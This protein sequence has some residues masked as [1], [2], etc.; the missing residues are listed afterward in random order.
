M[1]SNSEAQLDLQPE[2][3]LNDFQSAWNEKDKHYEEKNGVIEVSGRQYQFKVSF[4]NLRGD[5]MGT[6]F[7]TQKRAITEVA[8]QLG[9]NARHDV[10][11]PILPGWGETSAQFEGDFLNLVLEVLQEAGFENPKVLGIN[12]SGRGTPDYIQD[13]SRGRIS[14]IGMMDEVKD[15]SNIANVLMMRGYFGDK[16]YVPNVA[17][18]GHSMGSLDA[19]SFLDSLNY[20]EGPG[21]RNRDEDLRV[22]KFL[23]MMPA[24]DGPFAMVRARFLWAVRKQVMESLKQAIPGKGALSLNEQDYHRIMFGDESFRD[25]EQYARSVPDSARRFLQLTLNPTRKFKDVFSKDGTGD[26]V[27]LTV[28]KGG[29]DKL[30]P[31]N[32]IM[33]LPEFVGRK[34]LKNKVD[35]NELPDLS[36][37]IPFRL[38]DAQRDQV[39]AALG[40]FFS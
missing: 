14:A 9:A 37:S 19:I 31:D 3:R 17:V 5:E 18:M 27:D 34:G 25:A 22:R 30:I 1:E 28:W 32:A 11:V 12:P 21:R 23:S 40:K 13:E 36:H 38:R 16:R 20:G 10:I 35:V 2:H 29:K 8:P 4:L 7:S 6:S 33:D 26:G 39:K 15:S 24:V